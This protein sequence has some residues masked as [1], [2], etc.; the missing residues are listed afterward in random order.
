MILTGKN[1]FGLIWA[2]FGSISWICILVPPGFG[3]GTSGTR[4]LDV[5]ITLGPI[6][7][8]KPGQAHLILGWT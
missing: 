7:E 6:A 2:H 4:V 8:V 1:T 3:P 5:A